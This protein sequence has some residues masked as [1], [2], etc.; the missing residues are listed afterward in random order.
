MQWPEWGPLW[1]AVGGS[2]VLVAALRA[3]WPLVARRLKRA[4]QAALADDKADATAADAGAAMVSSGAL[5]LAGANQLIQQLQEEMATHRA[6]IAALQA[7]R[8][9]I[10]AELKTAALLLESYK[11]QVARLAQDVALR[12][13]RIRELEQTV[14]TQHREIT[15]LEAEVATLRAERAERIGKEGTQHG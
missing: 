2:G 3:A 9:A 4:G 5:L 13:E 14:A 8:E 7:D 12:T 6:Q 1:T 10:R 15:R 11:D